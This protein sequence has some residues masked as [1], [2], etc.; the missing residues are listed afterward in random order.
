MQYICLHLM[1]KYPNIIAEYLYRYYYRRNHVSNYLGV[2]ETNG[3]GM[4]HLHTLIWVRGT[5]NYTTLRQW[6]L[7]SYDFAVRMIR[8]LEAIIVHSIDNHNLDN[9]KDSI[10]RISIST[11]MCNRES[12]QEF[13]YKLSQDSNCVTYK[14]QIHSTKHN[15]A[16]PEL[17]VYARVM[18][19]WRVRRPGSLQA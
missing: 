13:L 14:Q 9:Q 4:L 10:L 18:D 7:E 3:R 6:V 12:N 2:T 8:Y 17:C 5:Y 1:F 11:C 15:R 16:V 19:I